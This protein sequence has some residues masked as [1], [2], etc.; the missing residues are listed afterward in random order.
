MQDTKDFP[1]KLNHVR[2]IPKERSFVAVDVK[3]LNT[4]IPNNE[5]TKAVREAY[6]KHPSKLLSTKVTITFLI[7]IL[8]LNNFIINCSH[9]L[10]VVRCAI[11]TICAP[12]FANTF[13]TQFEAKHIY[14]YI[15]GNALLFLRYVDHIFMLWKGTTEELILF[16][17]ELD[18]MVYRDQ[19]HKIQTEIFRKPTNQQTY[20][21]AQSNLPKSLKESIPYSQAL[22]IKTVCS[23][24]SEFD[25]NHYKKI[26]RKR[27]FDK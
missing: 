24:T 22:H 17:D 13:M 6:D 5:G 16:I 19:Q 21:H 7:L 1:T 20:L 14:L 2:H 12:A 10:Q 4:S 9:Y 18:T 3:P 15:H 25:K 8:T 11:G 23:T 27:R 26:Q